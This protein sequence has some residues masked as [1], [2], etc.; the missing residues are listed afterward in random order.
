MD[1]PRNPAEPRHSPG[2]VGRDPADNLGGDKGTLYGIEGARET[3]RVESDA[4]GASHHSRPARR[5]SECDAG[6]AGIRT[7]GAVQ[8]VGHRA[9]KRREEVTVNVPARIA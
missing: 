9:M 8:A 7:A 1:R 6:S 2:M 5:R 4:A 3:R